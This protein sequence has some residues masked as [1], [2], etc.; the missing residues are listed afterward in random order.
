MQSW[1]D[2]NKSWIKTSQKAATQKCRNA[3]VADENKVA[4]MSR[5]NFF[6]VVFCR[7]DD[8]FLKERWTLALELT[9]KNKGVEMHFKIKNYQQYV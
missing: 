1:W 2:Q 5:N 9:D 6:K 8:R 3:A 4:S 7:K